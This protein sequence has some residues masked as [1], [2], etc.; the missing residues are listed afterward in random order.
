MPN[1]LYEHG[2]LAWSLHQADLLRRLGREEQVNDVDWSNVAEKIESVGL[3]ELH[4]LESFLT[5][6]ITPCPEAARLAA[7]R[8]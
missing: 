8:I 1:G 3:S 5:L 7:Q 6:I 2:V 4:D